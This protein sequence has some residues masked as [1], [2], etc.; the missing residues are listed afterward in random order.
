MR[1]IVAAVLGMV[2]SGPALAEVTRT[3]KVGVL[4]DFAGPLAD[5]SGQGSVEAA[6]LAVE[7][8][9]KSGGR[10]KVEIVSADHQNKP[11]VASAIARKWISSDGVNAILDVP[12]SGVALA[13]NEITRGSK[14]A[15]L[16]SA[17]TNIDLIGK[18]CSPNTVM[19]TTDSW[20]LANTVA[21]GVIGAGK[22]TWFFL[23]V[24]F[25]GGIGLEQGATAA[26]NRAGGQVVGRARFPFDTMD[27]AS[28]LLQAQGAGTQAVGFA[29]A[30]TQLTGLLK[31]AHEFGLGQG[32]P[33]LVGL[34]IF[35]TDVHSLGLNVAQGLQLAESYYWDLNNDTRAFAKRFAERHGGKYPTQMQAGAY[36]ALTHYLKAVDALGSAD[37]PSVV[38]KMK[39]LPTHDPLFGDGFIRKD[40]RTMHDHFLFEVKAPGESRSE[41]D[42]YKLLMRVPAEEAFRAME[43]GG[44]PLVSGAK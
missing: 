34:A 38:Q 7:D 2:L 32:K 40:G 25:A 20:A 29:A 17:A 43:D 35:L 37:G 26:V 36:A 28:F 5:W 44:C 21:K 42:L 1:F 33:Q 31:Q 19:W 15:L 16:A 14:A 18:A 23:T 8:Y 6:K 4:T 10:S 3:V 30:G 13:V 22:K 9:V 24:D 39:D 11:D 27:Y 41:W 12:N